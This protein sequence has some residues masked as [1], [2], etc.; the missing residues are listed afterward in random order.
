VRISK[1]RESLA[2]DGLV[3]AVLV[4]AAELAMTVAARISVARNVF[5]ICGLGRL[6]SLVLA[7]Q[8][9]YHFNAKVQSGKDAKEFQP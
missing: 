5:M 4:S 7:V 8:H 6:L 9:L 1:Q 3:G 2:T